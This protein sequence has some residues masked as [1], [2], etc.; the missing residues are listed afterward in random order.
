MT[1]RNPVEWLWSQLSQSAQ[2][3]GVVGG[4]LYHQGDEV[5]ARTIPINRIGFADLREALRRG[6]NDF[7]SYRSDVLF[8]VLI[9]PI[10]G[11]VLSQLAV[12]HSML[13]LIFPLASGFALLGP[14]AATGLYEVSRRRERGQDITWFEAFKVF[15]SPAFGSVALLGAIMTVFFLLWLLV[16]MTIYHFTLGPA[17]PVSMESFLADVFG[18]GAGWA[19]MIIGGGV[20]FVFA[21]VVLATGS[22]SFPL[23]IDRHV[24]VVAAV[25][26][27]VH[28]FTVNL[29]P[30]LAWGAIVAGGLV[31]G[32]LPL[33]VGLIV[34]MPILGHATWHLYRRLTAP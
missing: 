16:A 23:L 24:G 17:Y 15:S 19:L 29:V 4:S 22:I 26:A 6:L 5:R 28:A 33:L 14:F 11:L 30:M 13:P 20:G 7:V 32:S 10:A 27:S 9:Y 1:I 18:T 2:V 25:G 34:V 31:L 21:L 12:G 3:V 8:I